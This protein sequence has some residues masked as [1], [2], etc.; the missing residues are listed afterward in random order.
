MQQKLLSLLSLVHF[1]PFYTMAPI[2]AMLILGNVTAQV[3][4]LQAS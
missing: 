4:K 1:Q 3:V 2:Q